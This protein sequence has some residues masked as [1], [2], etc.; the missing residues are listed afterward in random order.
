MK[1]V[2]KTIISV[3][4]WLI[5]LL[6]FSSIGFATDNP[7]LGIPLYGVFFILVFAGVYFFNSRQK[8]VQ[9]NANQ[10]NPIFSRIV[11]II[12]LIGA[13]LM[14]YFIFAE[15]KVPAS[16]YA[17]IILITAVM[18]TIAFFTIRM[19]NHAGGKFTVK[20]IG[21][22][23]LIALASI[24]AIGSMKYF[25]N[26]FNRPYDALGMSYWCLVVI[27]ILSW[28]GFALLGKRK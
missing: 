1:K 28:W 22:L 10:I 2:L 21:Y 15:I 8:H 24:P 26:Y 4:G 27:S 20:L 9:G 16:S 14:P 18:I 25:L 17:V 11:G 23:I 12:A 13:L 7:K 5:L 19:I 3:L 6:A